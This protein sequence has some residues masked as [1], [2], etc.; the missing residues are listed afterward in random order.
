MRALALY[1]A[2]SLHLP[3]HGQTQFHQSVKS[4]DNNANHILHLV[5]LHLYALYC[6]V[7]LLTA[8]CI[9]NVTICILHYIITL[10]ELDILLHNNFCVVAFTACARHCICQVITLVAYHTYQAATY[11]NINN[12]LL[13]T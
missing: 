10:Y 9:V 8:L 4:S 11:I 1:W 3:A 12:A 5:L 6:I 2:R 7:A 13:R